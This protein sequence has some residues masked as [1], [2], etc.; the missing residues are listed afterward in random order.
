MKSP[1]G[2]PHDYEVAV[3]AAKLWPNRKHEASSL[4][5]LFCHLGIHRWR[6][7]NL[8]KLMP[9]KDILHC[10]W[11]SRVKVDGVVYDV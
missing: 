3:Q 1:K 2:T 7:L 6:R 4:F 10:F 11:C 5:G 9:N 8:A